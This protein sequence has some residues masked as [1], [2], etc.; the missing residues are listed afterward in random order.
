[1]KAVVCPV[2]NGKRLLPPGFYDQIGEWY[3][4][5]AG[6]APEICRSC[7]GRGWVEVHEDE[8]E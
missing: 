5:T 4:S 7:D 6:N 3:S 1:M 2:C 8:G